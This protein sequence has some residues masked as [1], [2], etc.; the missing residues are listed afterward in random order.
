M[1]TVRRKKPTFIQWLKKQNV[2]HLSDELGVARQTI[3]L[4]INKDAKPNLHNAFQITEISNG[5]LTVE[6]ILE[7]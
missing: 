3:Y 6:D 1:N 7:G 2:T 5:V 4:W